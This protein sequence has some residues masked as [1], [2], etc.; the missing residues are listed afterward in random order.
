[1]GQF[2]RPNRPIGPKPA[3]ETGPPGLRC[4]CRLN[5]G[6]SG[7]AYPVLNPNMKCQLNCIAEHRDMPGVAVGWIN[8]F[9]VRVAY[10][11]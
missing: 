1:V 10:D 11:F 9:G 3:H 2:V 7:T 6:R 4:S 5:R 8:G